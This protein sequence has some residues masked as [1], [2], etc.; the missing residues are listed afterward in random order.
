MS[1][2]LDQVLGP[3]LQTSG[4]PHHDL[5]YLPLFDEAEPDNYFCVVEEGG[6]VWKE[7]LA[8]RERIVDDDRKKK[9]EKKPTK[10]DQKQAFRFSCLRGSKEDKEQLGP[11]YPVL[12]GN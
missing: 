8:L 10:K 7:C 6:T 11:G 2:E 12:S 3:P 1:W 4:P 5:Q 9:K